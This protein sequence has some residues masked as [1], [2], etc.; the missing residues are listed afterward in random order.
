VACWCDAARAA[1]AGFAAVARATPCDVGEAE[2]VAAAM[3]DLR[4]PSAGEVSNGTVLVPG[5]GV[6]TTA[7]G[8]R[9]VRA[10]LNERAMDTPATVLGAAAALAGGRPTAMARADGD[11]STRGGGRV[12][13][14]PPA[15]LVTHGRARA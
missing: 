4:A 7:L 15:R 1:V 8:R 14:E 13:D 3:I 5:S 9:D 11:H 2:D 12:A 10:R 6:V